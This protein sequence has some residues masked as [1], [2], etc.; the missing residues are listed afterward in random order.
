MSG[1]AVTP[2][3]SIPTH[4]LSRVSNAAIISLLSS[5]FFIWEFIT[6][7]IYPLPGKVAGSGFGLGENSFR[8]IGASGRRSITASDPTRKHAASGARS[9]AVFQFASRY[10][11]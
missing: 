1:P 7:I 2:D 11:P 3:S 9:A 8:R 6:V 4:S 5:L 10:T